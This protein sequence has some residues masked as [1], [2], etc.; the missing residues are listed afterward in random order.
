MPLRGR[1]ARDGLRV[2]RFPVGES[3]PFTAREPLRMGLQSPPDG[4]GARGE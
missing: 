2:A 1:V 3:Q 4:S